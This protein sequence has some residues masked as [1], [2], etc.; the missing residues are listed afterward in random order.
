MQLINMSFNG[1]IEL[2]LLD[3]QR[4]VELT[5][6]SPTDPGGTIWALSKYLWLEDNSNLHEIFTVNCPQW[7][8]YGELFKFDLG[9]VVQKLLALKVKM[10]SLESKGN[11]VH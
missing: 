11:H 7:N 2:A 9:L 8:L 6:K 1:W 10:E 5:P 3:G 4:E